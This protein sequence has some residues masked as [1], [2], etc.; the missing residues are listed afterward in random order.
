MTLSLPDP[1]FQPFDQVNPFPRMDAYESSAVD[2]VTRRLQRQLWSGYYQL[3][4]YDAYYEGEQPLQYMSKAMLEEVGSI[5]RAVVLNWCRLGADMYATRM[6][7]DGFRFATDEQTDSRLWDV[8]QANGLDS[9]FSEGI[10]EA[11]ALG[12]S[13]LIIGAPDEPGGK[14]VIT[15][16]SPFQVTWTRSPRTRKLTDACK[17]WTDEAGDAY[18]TLYQPNRTVPLRS[19]GSR[20]V[21]NGEIDNHNLGR[22]PVVPLV[23]RS[24]ILRPNGISE[25]HD[26]IPVVDAAIKAATD[27]MVSAEYHAMPRRWVFGLKKDD[28]KDQHGNPVSMW[29]RIAGRIW[30]SENKEVN[31]GQFPEAALSNFHDTIKLLGRLVAQI[32]ASPEALSFDSVNP[33]SAESFG[34]MNAERDMRVRAKH[35]GFGEAAEDAMRLVLRIMDGTYDEKAE[36]IETVWADPSTMTFAQRADGTVKLVQA[37]DGQGRSIITVEQAREDLGYGPKARERMAQQDEAARKAALDALRDL[38]DQQTEVDD[39]QPDEAIPGQAAKAV[40]P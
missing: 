25:F 35:V 20:W 17:L 34:A 38:A 31:V 28:F 16:E 39:P 32:L 3:Q 24:R 2:F 11:L 14:P 12:R 4:L 1:S 30:S 22:V 10:L 27:M 5:I 9:L 8:W 29:S 19:N 36:S 18:A 23:N 21:Q 40:T 13:A 7:I 37:K 26:I 6:R 15:V 33:P